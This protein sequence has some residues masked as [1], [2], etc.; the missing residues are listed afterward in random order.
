MLTQG[1]VQGMGLGWV[2]GGGGRLIP[3][4]QGLKVMTGRGGAVAPCLKPAYLFACQKRRKETQ[5]ADCS[6]LTPTHLL[7]QSAALILC[8]WWGQ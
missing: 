8:R 1:P 2:R 6:L 3:A 7:I 5:R 4:K